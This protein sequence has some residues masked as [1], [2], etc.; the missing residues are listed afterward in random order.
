[1]AKKIKRVHDKDTRNPL[2]QDT[3]GHYAGKQ[4]AIDIEPEDEGGRV[5]IQFTRPTENEAFRHIEE[6][7]E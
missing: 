4:T 5:K 2:W 3:H 6:E 7:A 1:M